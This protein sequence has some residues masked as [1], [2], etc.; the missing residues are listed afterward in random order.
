MDRIGE[1]LDDENS[2]EYI[3]NN[4]VYMKLKIGWKTVHIFSF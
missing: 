2:N 4:K 3:D 1:D